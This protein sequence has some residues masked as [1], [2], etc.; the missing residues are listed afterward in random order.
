MLFLDAASEGGG[1]PHPRIRAREEKLTSRWMLSP[2]CLIT[3]LEFLKNG[4]QAA[5]G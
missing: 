5:K 3:A 2:L 1:M 4:P